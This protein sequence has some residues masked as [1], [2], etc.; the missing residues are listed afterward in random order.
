[1]GPGN[2]VLHGGPDPTWEEAILRRKGASHCKVQTLC[3]HL[4]ENDWTERDAI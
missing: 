2:H 1:V 4:C 3:G